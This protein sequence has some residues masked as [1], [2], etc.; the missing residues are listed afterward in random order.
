MFRIM[1]H[2]S[3][4]V[5]LIFCGI[6]VSGIDATDNETLVVIAAQSMDEMNY[7][8]NIIDIN[9][10]EFAFGSIEATMSRV[11]SSDDPHLVTTALSAP[12]LTRLTEVNFDEDNQMWTLEYETARYDGQSI[13]SFK[14]YLY[15]SKLGDVTQGDTSNECLQI[16]YSNEQC[17][18]SLTSKYITE[19]NLTPENESLTLPSPVISEVTRTDGTLID[20]IELRIP[21]EHVTQTMS[22]Q[23]TNDHYLDGVR[24][25]YRFGIGML[26]LGEQN[27]YVIFDNFV[28][29]HNNNQLVTITQ[30]NAYAIS[31]HVSF[32]TRKLFNSDVVTATVELLLHKGYSLDKIEYDVNGQAVTDQQCSNVQDI[33]SSLPDSRCISHHPLCHP[34]KFTSSDDRQWV[35]L[36]IPTTGYHADNSINLN[37][38]L[39]ATQKSTNKTILSALN[40]ATQQAPQEVCRDTQ[41]ITVSPVDYTKAT[42]YR[43]SSLHPEVVSGHFDV[44]RSNLTAESIIE[45]LLTIVIEPDATTAASTYFARFTDEVIQLDQVYISH[46]LHAD[47]VP[48]DLKNTVQITDNGRSDIYLDSQLQAKCSNEWSHSFAATDSVDCITTHD[49]SLDGKKDRAKSSP[50]MYFVWEFT[51]S[52]KDLKWLDN[53]FGGSNRTA[54][55]TFFQNLVAKKHNDLTRVYLLHPVYSWQDQSVL[56]L[57]DKSIISLSWSVTSVQTSTS[58]RR[59]MSVTGS[60]SYALP[61]GSDLRKTPPSRTASSQQIKLVVPSDTLKPRPTVSGYANKTLTALRRHRRG[62]ILP[63]QYYRK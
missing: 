18:A 34:V 45:A 46:F 31:Q 36:V 1:K 33:I 35:T 7:L 3:V 25:E 48:S 53:I 22:R 17:L 40:F 15:S 32:Y 4:C 44:S 49:W 61:S 12:S 20:K 63:L 42:L 26:F 30:D 9:K 41:E 43:G 55:W 58:N 8:A 10:S 14:R 2:I 23:Y 38:L 56:E 21:H 37:L 5:I 6:S 57:K 24:T 16:G 11:V 47:Q 27:N 29:V 60:K 59:L 52:D 28:L 54:T 19:D 51:N 62:A 13:N 39:T 50:G